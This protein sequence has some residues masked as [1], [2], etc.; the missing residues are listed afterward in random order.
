MAFVSVIGEHE[1]S[2]VSSRVNYFYIDVYINAETQELAG[3]QL[4]AL[5][6][7]LLHLGIAWG[8]K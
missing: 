1:V 4:S 3:L 8:G 7:Q 5:P 6:L 2:H